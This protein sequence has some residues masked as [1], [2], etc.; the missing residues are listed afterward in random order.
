VKGDININ[1]SKDFRYTSW[2]KVDN[3]LNYQIG[4]TDKALKNEQRF[5]EL[6]YRATEELINYKN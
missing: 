3:E 6:F 2:A 4:K 1:T 5:I